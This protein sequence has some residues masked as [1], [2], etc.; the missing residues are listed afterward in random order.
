MQAG[1]ILSKKTGQLCSYVE[2]PNISIEEKAG[3]LPF[4]TLNKRQLCDY[5]LLQNGGFAPLNSFMN[6]RD[7]H[8]TIYN[9]RLYNGDLWTMPIVLSINEGQRDKLIHEDFVCLKDETGIPLAI[10][11]ISKDH[12]IYSVKLKDECLNV[13][14]S[15][16]TN[17]PYVK[18]LH[19]KYKDGFIY[20]IGG[21]FVCSTP[22]LHYDFSDIRLTPQQTRDLFKR[23]GWSKVVGF[24]TRN[25]MHRS[26]YELTKYALRVAGQDAHVMLHPVIG[27]TQ[28]C[29][30]DYHTRV[31]CYKHLLNYYDPDQALLNLLPL[32]MRMA[33]PREAVWH[34]QIRK[35]YGCTHFVVGRDHAGPSYKTKEGEDFY[36]HYD[37]QNL[38]LKFAPEIGI[39]P[40]ISKMIVY[41]VPKNE[42]NVMKGKYMPIDEVNQEENN[43]MKISGTQQREMLRSGEPIPEWFTF[44]P[45]SQELK[46]KYT[47]NSGFTLY[48]IGLSGSGKSTVSN[49]LI[50]KLKEI[51]NKSVTYLDGDIVRLHLS[52]G[53]SFSKADKSINVRRIGYVCS[54][55]TKH[56]GIAIA[57][58]IAPFEEDRQVNRNLV[59]QYGKYIE[60]YMNVSIETCEKRDVKGLYKLARKD[61]LK[62][63]SGV[64]ST[65]DEPVNAD[66]VLNETMSIDE[67]INTITSYLYRNNLI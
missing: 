62:D 42:P 64:N 56:G 44:P 14:G 8:S 35:N 2:N 61:I 47:V 7:Y 46:E 63:F 52:K 24:Q 43:V 5:E 22:P 11:D 55:V 16:D 41:A 12:S 59:E 60:V 53:L 10:M 50:S 1:N 38:L 37:A 26:H 30:V 65:F 19:Q 21:N 13:Y 6:K 51:T 15:N 9:M 20:N 66:I 36:G 3:K 25:P 39:T 45:V 17:H 54:E 48:F 67:C 34:A 18:I 40:V 27:I 4:I 29:D 28:D 32:S 58:N 33:G 49:Y 23:N 57:S 31:K